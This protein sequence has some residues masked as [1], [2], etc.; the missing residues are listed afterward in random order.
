MILENES[1]QMTILPE[2]GGKILSIREVVSGRE[3]LWHNPHLAVKL[4]MHGASYIETMDS[5][6]WDEIFPSVTPDLVDGRVIPDHGD[7][8]G[9]PWKVLECDATRCVMEVRTRFAD[10]V[11]KRNIL[12]DSDRLTMDYELRNHEAVA[13]PSIWCAHPLLALEPGMRIE[14]PH[15]TRMLVAGGVAVP[16]AGSEFLWPNLPGLPPLDVIPDIHAADFQPLAIKMF[17]AAK[18]VD[19][20]KVLAADG[21]GGLEISW[22]AE[23][24]PYLGLWLNLRAW[25]GCGSSPYCNLGVEPTTAQADALS[26]ALAGGGGQWLA[27]G[28]SVKWSIQ[29]KFFC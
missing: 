4:P 19:R 14:L 1:L 22:D 3:W 11:F 29:V 13:V 9:L 21:D 2:V 12:L 17:T 10:C 24:I 6:G 8:V 20:V 26:D 15:G 18:A 5:G 7:L 23:K 25:S 27:A 16:E 28:A